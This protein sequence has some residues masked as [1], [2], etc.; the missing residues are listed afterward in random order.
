[1]LGH[2]RGDWRFYIGCL[3]KIPTEEMVSAVERRSL[4]EYSVFE[5]TINSN[6]KQFSDNKR[7]QIFGLSE[8][9]MKNGLV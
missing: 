9:P 7:F 6:W 1:M 5:N 8:P 4:K 2:K 3:F